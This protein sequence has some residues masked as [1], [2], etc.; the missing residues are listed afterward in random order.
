[1]SNDNI[2]V[3]LGDGIDLKIIFADEFTDDKGKVV[4]YGDSIKLKKGDYEF[5]LS[6]LNLARV[7]HALHDPTIKAVLQERF[8]E[9]MEMIQETPGF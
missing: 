9:E 3:S 6:A 4:K 2:S 1:M 5:K 7:Y 8:V